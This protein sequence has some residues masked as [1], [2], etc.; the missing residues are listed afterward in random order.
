MI[1]EKVNIQLNLFDEE[2]HSQYSI[3]YSS[4]YIYINISSSYA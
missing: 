2:L 1:I 3:M 4:Y